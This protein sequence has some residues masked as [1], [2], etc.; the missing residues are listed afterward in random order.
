M[1]RT[2]LTTAPDTSLMEVLK[3]M[4]ELNVNRV[5]VVE[6]G[7]VIGVISRGDIIF[8]LYQKKV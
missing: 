5:P 3:A 2:V 7:V 1:V 6:Q 4:I 8:A